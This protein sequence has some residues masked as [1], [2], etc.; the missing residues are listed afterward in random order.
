MMNLFCLLA[1]RHFAEEHELRAL[2]AFPID[3]D[4]LL[5]VSKIR[6]QIVPII[7]CPQLVLHGLGFLCVF[8]Q[9]QGFN[10]EEL[11]FLSALELNFQWGLLVLI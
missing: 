9:A 7:Q 8:F 3:G 5:N 2:P 1:E 6:L 10:I 4:S 11:D